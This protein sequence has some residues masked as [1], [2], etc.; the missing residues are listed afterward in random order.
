[1]SHELVNIDGLELRLCALCEQLCQLEE[2]KDGNIYCKRCSHKFANRNLGAERR[3]ALRAYMDGVVSQVKQKKIDV[4]HISEAAS[5][6]LKKFHGGVEGW[7][8]QYYEDM[9]LLRK[10]YPGS[11]HVMRV[12]EQIAK[13]VKW[14]TEN[15]STAPDVHGMSDDQIKAEL[16]SIV[17]AELIK[18]GESA[19]SEFLANLD[20]AM[21]EDVG[22]SE[23]G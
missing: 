5:Q 17:M 21:K 14:S 1:M 3:K 12:H 6:F 16:V 13:L 4:P 7:V 23:S 22:T 8:E 18:G 11:P 15:R 2:F 19:Q 10:N 20:G 9:Q